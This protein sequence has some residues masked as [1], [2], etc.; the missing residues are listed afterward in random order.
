M[1]LSLLTS[2]SCRAPKLPN[3][4]T[5]EHLCKD[6]VTLSFHE[7]LV[8]VLHHAQCLNEIVC[9]ESRSCIQMLESSP[10]RRGRAHVNM[11]NHRRVLGVARASSA[12]IR[13]E[14]AKLQPISLL[15]SVLGKCVSVL[16]STQRLLHASVKDD[17]LAKSQV[18]LSARD[19]KPVLNAEQ[20]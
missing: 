19:M 20:Q 7:F 14:I 8:P 1:P 18:A 6:N 16:Y 2:A 13:S 9:A 3:V 15:R 4:E 11:L 17:T 5:R 12:Q 10:C